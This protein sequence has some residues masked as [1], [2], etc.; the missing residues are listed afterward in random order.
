MNSSPSLNLSGMASKIPIQRYKKPESIG[1]HNQSKEIRIYES[2]YTQTRRD[3]ARARDTKKKMAS[4]P[5]RFKCSTKY[6]AISG[7]KLSSTRFYKTKRNPNCLVTNLQ[8]SNRSKI[9]LR[10]RSKEILRQHR[11][12]LSIKR[13]KERQRS[14]TSSRSNRTHVSK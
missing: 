11:H 10:V 8:R 6:L 2:K 14:S 4:I 7:T 1:R 3:P 5:I 13:T 9:H 12:K